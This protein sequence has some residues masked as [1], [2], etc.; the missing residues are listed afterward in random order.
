MFKDKRKFITKT[1]VLFNIK[2]FYT[3]MTTNTNQY[4]TTNR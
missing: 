3:I 4:M 1:I 2:V